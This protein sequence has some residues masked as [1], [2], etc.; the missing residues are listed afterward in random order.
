[1]NDNSLCVRFIWQDPST[2]RPYDIEEIENLA[3]IP[4]VGEEIEIQADSNHLHPFEFDERFLV[5]KVTYRIRSSPS[6]SPDPMENGKVLADEQL[7]TIYV[8]PLGKHAWSTVQ[9]IKKDP[10][11]PRKRKDV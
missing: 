7:V 8:Q 10:D 4:R 1:M 9:R 11:S 3:F 5:E 2:Q 6:T